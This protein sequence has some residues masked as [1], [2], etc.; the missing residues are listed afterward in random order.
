MSFKK[1][2]IK[3]EKET[4]YI[5]DF[6]KKFKKLH[7]LSKPRS[8]IFIEFM[9]EDLPDEWLID[10][11]RYKKKSRIVVEHY[12]ILRKQLKGWIDMYRNEGW[13]FLT[14]D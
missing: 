13:E 11:V 1:T 6:G 10:V 9:T 2:F 4:K 12:V 7:K 5:D 8:P 14:K 3:K